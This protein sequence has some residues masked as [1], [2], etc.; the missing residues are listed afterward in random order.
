[1]YMIKLS[2]ACWSRIHKH[3]LACCFKNSLR[4]DRDDDGYTFD[5]NQIIT[6]IMVMTEMIIAALLMIKV[7]G[8]IMMIMV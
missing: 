1:M 8:K 4:T 3:F 6:M 7:M 2:F 5:D